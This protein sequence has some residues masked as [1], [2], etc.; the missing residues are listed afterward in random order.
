MYVHEHRTVAEV[1]RLLQDALHR[2]EVVP[3]DRSEIREA[4]LLKE[5]VRDEEGLE[6]GEEAP[7]RL[8]GEV[9]PRHVVDDLPR[10]L[11]RAAVRGRGPERLEHP[12]DRADVR[13]DAHPIVVQ[14][15]DDACAHVADV[16]EALEGHAGRE[17]AVADD[18]DDVVVFVP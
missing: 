7:A 12:R 10:Y 4:E 2:E 17:R 11:L 16:V 9:A 1:P 18:R 5:Q 14:H 8:L 3:I 6:A 13:R 15:H